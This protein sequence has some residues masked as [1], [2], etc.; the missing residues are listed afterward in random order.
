MHCYCL[1]SFNQVQVFLQKNI[2]HFF[3]DINLNPG[4][5]PGTDNV[6]LLQILPFHECIFWRRVLLQSK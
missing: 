3:G 6:N 4:S 2:A 1:D 5:V